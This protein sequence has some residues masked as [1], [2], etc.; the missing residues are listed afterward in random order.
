MNKNVYLED[1]LQR[2]STKALWHFT[3]YNKN[4]EDA[5]QKLVSILKDKLLKVSIEPVPIIMPSRNE[6]WG[7]PC[8]CMCDIPFKDLKIH[9]A[10]YGCFGIAF[11]KENAILKGFF[12]PVL[13][14]HKDH[15]LLKHVE[16]LLD[17]LEKLI[18]P[19]ERLTEAL[20]EFLRILGTYVKPGDL[21]STVHLDT[22][23]DE[24]QRNNFYYEREWRSAYE[25][26]FSETDVI[27]VMLPQKYISEFKAIKISEFTNISIISAEIVETL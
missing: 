4:E 18:S 26:K 27:A 9:T 14:M 8:S 19:H 12:N 25:W 17:E 16:K 7:Y 21:L 20:D 24:E 23:I 11:K 6:R 22:V 10:R 3:G 1:Y 2:F 13:Y 5:Y 15:H